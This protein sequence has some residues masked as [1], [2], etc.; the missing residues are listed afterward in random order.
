VT[1]VLLMK[2]QKDSHTWTSRVLKHNKNTVY[3]NRVEHVAN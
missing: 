1:F 3:V 2:T